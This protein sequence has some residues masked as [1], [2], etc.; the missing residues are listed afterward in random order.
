MPF[1]EDQLQFIYFLQQIRGPVVDWIFRG[2]NFFDTDYYICSLIAFTWIGCSWRWGA[3]LGFLL[4]GSTWI[5]GIVKVAF[6]LPRPFSFDSSLGIVHLSGFGFPSGG[7]QTAML[8]G[9]LLI[10][11]WKNRWAWLIGI[12]YILLISFSR[13]FLGVHFPMDVLG[14]WILGMSIFLIYIKNGQQIERWCAK[15]PGTAL[16]TALAIS[17][18]LWLLVRD[19]KTLYLMASLASMSAGVYLSVKHH[20]YFNSPRDVRKKIFLG[21]FGMLSA[22]GLTIIARILPLNPWAS[23]AAQISAGSVW[24]TLLASPFCKRAFF[25]FIR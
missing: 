18:F 14:G 15:S 1:L 25:S 6:S 17:L 7:A 2:L 19:C 4:I 24:I 20:L 21:L 16:W 3:R 9:C 13:I 10:Y 23:L 8:L 22:F 5:N 11:F 12:F